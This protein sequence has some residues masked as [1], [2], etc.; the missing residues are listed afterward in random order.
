M[1][2]MEKIKAMAEE[3]LEASNRYEICC[4]EYRQE[5][6][7]TRSI[8]IA[9]A[10]TRLHETEGRL[11]LVDLAHAVLVYHRAASILW[12]MCRGTTWVDMTVEQA[13]TL[14]IE[15]AEAELAEEGKSDEE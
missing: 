2:D 7:S 1:L 3:V 4:A 12:Q 6:T 13:W 10:T 8:A 14:C 5:P 15:Q 11:P 9:A